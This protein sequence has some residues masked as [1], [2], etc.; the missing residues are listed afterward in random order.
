MA[1]E[2]DRIFSTAGFM[3]HGMCYLWRPDV[4]ALHIVSDFL[5][6]LAYFSIPFTLLHFVRKRSDLEFNW[7]FVCFAIFIVACG[8]THL[9]EIWVIWHPTYWLSGAI[10]AITALASVPT[11][12]LLVRLL[13]AALALPSPTALRGAYAN[14]ESE[15]AERRR[16]EEELRIANRQLREEAVR[17]RLAAIVESSEDAIISKTTDGTI[18]S[19]NR[20]AE[21]IFGYSASEAIG[22]QTAMLFPAERADEEVEILRRL[23]RGEQVDSFETVR[24]RND[25]ERIDVF[26]TISPI[27]DG[28][29]NVVGASEIALNI[30]ER[31]RAEEAL[32]AE[33]SSAAHRLASQLSR[34]HLM[35]AITRAIGER[36]DLASIFQ[37]V[38]RALEDELPIDFGCLCLYEPPGVLVVTRVGIKSH[39]LAVDLGMG[40][41]AHLEIDQNGLAG[42]MRGQLVYEP[43]LTAAEFE[44]PKRLAAGGLR[45]MVAAP[46][47]VD[48]ELF[49]V[50]IAAR[51]EPGSFSSDDCE[52]LGQLSEHVA[53]A[54]RQTQLYGTL[55]AAYE[56]L[57]QT[58]Q[59]VIRQEKLRVLGQMASGIAH[60]INNALSPAALYVESLLEHELSRSESRDYLMIIQRA[61]EGV[62]QTVARI[63]EF[64]SQ[65][66]PLLNHVS[67]CLNR[68]VE[69]A[70]ELTRPRWNA[71]PQESGLVI[72]V[73]M[74][75][76]PDLPAIAGVES[77]IRDALTNLVLNAVD[78]M[79]E[80][81]QL[82]LR[83]RAVAPDQ[84]QLDVT[85]SGIGMDEATRSRCLELFFT[86]KGVRGTGLG[87]AM[88]YGM[89]ERHGGEIQI[90]SE[91]GI[92][93]NVRLTFPS[94]AILPVSAGTTPPQSRPQP[95]LRILLVDDDPMILKSLLT[96]LEQDGHSVETA[97]GGQRGV[98]AFRA[99][100][101]RREPFGVVITDLGM[102][103]VDGRSVAAAVKSIRP[104]TP[105]ILL[106][107]WGHRLLAEKD[108]PSNVDR[109]L[110]KPPKLAGLRNVL[111]ELTRA[112]PV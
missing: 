23:E 111:A 2:V 47:L 97:D 48:N 107:G 55:Q 66:D 45:A 31:K 34:L 67:V 84:V 90:E 54:A 51:R 87:L 60:D 71:I 106:T 1:S 88:V 91:P 104:E 86:T 7:M 83:S 52:F 81:G 89:L 105:V 75:L 101:G 108:T 74:D 22:R 35:N 64:Y 39:Q 5:I 4:L 16:T 19:W 40:Q 93:T 112:P 3:P 26:A 41:Q 62:A 33:R 57:R 70:V 10:K 46:L 56:D 53:L 29:G 37:V 49:A 79:P 17:G 15:V 61:I 92:G 96:I 28:S 73:K 78:A 77:E 94:A 30:T 43:D 103:H 12:I 98:D 11:A 59:A 21:K 102:P 85:D 80:G 109:V 25:G 99:A 6:T 95:S 42:C 63:K 76:A 50:L 72:C 18:T 27:R 14:L 36:Q 32:G 110:G 24:V 82:T 8:T 65:R 100:Y 44:F 58:Q 38:I 69:Q 68:A 9:M 20:G 13:P